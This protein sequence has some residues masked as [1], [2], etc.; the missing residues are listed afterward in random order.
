MLRPSRWKDTFDP[1]A[2]FVVRR[3]FLCNGRNTIPGEPFDKESVRVHTLKAL[4][5]RRDLAMKDPTRPQDGYQ[6]TP[7]R[8]EPPQDIDGEIEARQGEQ[9]PP[10]VETPPPPPPVEK[11][12]VTAM[13]KGF[14][15]YSV[16]INDVLDQAGLTKAEAEARVLAG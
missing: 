16:F 11:R 3:K 10:P 14:G 15:K 5:T 12:K 6:P 7:P 13:H 8:Q 4:F 9:T 2:D 1:K